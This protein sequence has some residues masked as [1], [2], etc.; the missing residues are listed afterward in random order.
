EQTPKLLQ[1]RLL[2]V[3]HAQ[4]LAARAEQPQAIRDQACY[5]TLEAKR[6]LADR[7]KARRIQHDHVEAPAVLPGAAHETHGVGLHEFVTRWIEPVALEIAAAALQRAPGKIH[8]RQ[9]ARAAQRRRDAE[10]AGVSKQVQDLLLRGGL[11][12]ALAVV[13]L[14][15]EQARREAVAELAR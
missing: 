10:R 13:A 14:V 15:D 12:D 5:V 3:G 6:R 4:E 7:G 2:V 9:L 11:A 1:A 8:A